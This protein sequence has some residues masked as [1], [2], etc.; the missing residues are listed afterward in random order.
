MRAILPLALLLIAAAPAPDPLL[1]RIVA[2]A[3]AVSPAATAFERTMRSTGTE[4]KGAPET[5]VRTDR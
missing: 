2:G 3:R 1:E 4:E 5:H